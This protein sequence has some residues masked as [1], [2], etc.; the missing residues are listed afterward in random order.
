MAH[1]EQ[2]QTVPA[3]E[4]NRLRRE[5]VQDLLDKAAKW[6]A[7]GADRANEVVFH[8]P[9]QRLLWLVPGRGYVC[10]QVSLSGRPLVM[11]GTL[12][13]E[14][15]DGARIVFNLCHGRARRDLKEVTWGHYCELAAKGIE[16]AAE[17]LKQ[18]MEVG[19]G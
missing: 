14:Q 4:L 17:Y 6:R 12:T 18:L 15:L 1:Q 3:D 9:D 13:Q 19:H 16:S 10:M 7:L 2:P 11:A 5:M 8:D